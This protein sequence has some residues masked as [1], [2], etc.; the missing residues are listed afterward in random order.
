MEHFQTLLGVV[1]LNLDIFKSDI[2]SFPREFLKLLK[3]SFLLR[4]W[5]K[6][7]NNDTNVVAKIMSHVWS[8]CVISM[9]HCYN[10]CIWNEGTEYQSVLLRQNYLIYFSKYDQLFICFSAILSDGCCYWTIEGCIR[11]SRLKL[12]DI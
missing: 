9:R 5:N 4:R 8:I 2:S 10:I 3:C 1:F 6:F 11:T 7:L 12:I